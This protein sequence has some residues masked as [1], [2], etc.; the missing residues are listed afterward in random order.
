MKKPEDYGI[1]NYKWSKEGLL[2]V[3]GYVDLSNINLSKLPFKFGKVSGS[4]YC[5]KNQLETLQGVPKTV[6]GDFFCDNNILTTLEGAPQSVGGDFY[7]QGNQLK[8]LEGAPQEVGVGFYCGE[9]KLKS[10]QGAPKTVGGDFDCS[11][12]K[13]KTLEG[14]PK[15]VKGKILV[16]DNL[17]SQIYYYINVNQVIDYLMED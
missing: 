10:L 9:N 12:N 7:C 5:W 3:D 16:D 13:L 17:I 4:F 2:D 14:A 6:G 15:I 1:T 11:Y 8:T